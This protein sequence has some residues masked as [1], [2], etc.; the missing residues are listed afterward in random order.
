[1]LK[2]AYFLAKTGADTAENEQQFAEI[3]PIDR[4]IAAR[5]T[6][7]TLGGTRRPPGFCCGAAEIELLLDWPRPLRQ[8]EARLQN[9]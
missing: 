2:N 9:L 4:R 1:M 8:L 3:L 6:T 7:A 5:A